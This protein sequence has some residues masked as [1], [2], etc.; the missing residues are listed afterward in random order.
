MSKKVRLALWIAAIAAVL[1][2]PALAWAQELEGAALEEEA[3]SGG[4]M[5]LWAIIAGSGWL[6]IVLWSALILDSMAAAYLIIDFFITVSPKRIIPDALVSDVREAME[7]GD[8]MKAMQRCEQEPGSL[9]NILLAGFR[10]VKEGFDV[11]EEQVGAAADLESEKLMQRVSYLNMCGSIAPML[12]LLGTVQGMIAAFANLAT[13]QAGA[14]QQSMLAL[15]IAQALWTTA[16]G[17]VVAIPA[18]SFYTYFKNRLSRI[19]LSMEGLTLD[20]IKALR[21]VEVVEE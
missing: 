19:I 16:G 20:L 3:S 18:V 11:I 17:L 21:N 4:G 12:G 2:V 14:A 5:G 6:G 13:S 10:N 9:S 7:Q 1:F 8:V 15:N